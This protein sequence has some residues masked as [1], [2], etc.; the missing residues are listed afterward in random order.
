MLV[1]GTLLRIVLL[2]YGLFQDA[3]SPAVKYT[4]IDYS[5]FMD[6]AGFLHGGDSPYRRATY[7]YTPLLSYI[8]LPGFV[9]EG[10]GEVIHRLI[11]G[12]PGNAWKI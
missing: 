6:A 2:F 3:I 12:I 1:Q 10:S 4:D 9:L 7:R 8:L 5:V 11:P